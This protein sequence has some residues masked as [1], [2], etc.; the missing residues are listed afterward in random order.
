MSRIGLL[1]IRNMKRQ[2][3]RSICLFIAIAISTFLMTIALVLA[4]SLELSYGEY[5][6]ENRIWQGDAAINVYSTEDVNKISESD[7]VK[8]IGCEY[9][10]GYVMDNDDAAAN[11]AYYSEAMYEKMNCSPSEGT[12]PVE[13]NDIL[14]PKYIAQKAWA[15]C[16]IGSEITLDY[17]I[18]DNEV[19]DVFT[20]SGFYEQKVSTRNM[21]LVSE[22]YFLDKKQ[23]YID[24]GVEESQFPIM[25]VV[26]F[27]KNSN[28]EG[29]T[30]QLI[31]ET[32][33][34]VN[35]DEY[36][37]NE[38]CDDVLQNSIKIIIL[39]VSV[40]IIIIGGLLIVNIFELSLNNESVFYRSLYILG[41]S[42]GEVLRMIFIQLVMIALFANVFAII[43]AHISCGLV[44]VPFVN[45]MI[46]LELT[47]KISA[48][49]I[50]FPTMLSSLEVAFGLCLMMRHVSKRMVIIEQVECVNYKK[51]SGRWFSNPIYRMTMRRIA[52][53]KRAVI[54]IS[55][56]LFIGLVLC[57]GICS[58]IKGFD[59]NKYIGESLLADYV[60]HNATFDQYSDQIDVI[61]ESALA[62]LFN[63]DKEFEYASASAK[64][65]QVS[66][67]EESLDR[68]RELIQD[69][70]YNDGIITTHL[71]GLDDYFVSQ[72]DVLK[73]EI[74]IDKFR[75]G[76][77][78][79]LDGVSAPDKNLE[80]EDGN[81]WWNIGDKVQLKAADG[82][83]REY[84]IMAIVNMP[85]DLTVGTYY[86][87]T[88]N[89]FLPQSEWEKLT[90]ETSKY[91]CLFNVD[92][93]DKAYWDNRFEE[94]ESSNS[95]IT[96]Q[97]AKTVAEDNKELF[98]RI[99][100]MVIILVLIIFA[101]VIGGFFNIVVN[102]M[103]Q[104]KN[105]LIN[106]QRIGVSEKELVKQFILEVVSYLCIG[107]ILGCSSSPFIARGIINNLIDEDYVRYSAVYI[108]DFAYI[109][110]AIIIASLATVLY[111][112]KVI[113]KRFER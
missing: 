16:K 29:L 37:V 17:F 13:K 65:Y 48:K 2:K 12:V 32:N 68:Y 27:N 84:E 18:G 82:S 70:Q 81:S 78:L 67:D 35:T 60:V 93:S 44:L 38:E 46:N 109:F 110:V 94:L 19:S 22:K 111:K 71:Y 15:D 34:D 79:I 98:E 52:T 61:D 47:L 4:N 43:L 85:Y 112:K 77:Y 74:D 80:I 69:G 104:L 101:S 9:H 31:A 49:T 53:Q 51:R 56:I 5:L 108:V 6:K 97:S 24:K 42:K 39:I 107:I 57:N 105:E 3:M 59:I 50:V 106:L 1:S 45:S 113:V 96:Y 100:A 89:F 73:G 40:A 36:V 55:A 72:L 7:L 30:E 21:F 10:L 8:D 54:S 99:E 14:L 103:Y 28:F 90:G 87:D 41:V 102:E 91:I 64:D 11:I 95:N 86:N 88:C 62:P 92:E 58:Y 25:T 83:M 20:I 76:N 33:I 75:S 23:E 26:T 66:L 63:S